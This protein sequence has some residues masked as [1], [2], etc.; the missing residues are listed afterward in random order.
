MINALIVDDEPLARE[1]LI[2]LLAPHGDVRIA[3]ECEDGESAIERLSGGGIDLLFLDVQMPGIDGLSVAELAPASPLPVI[4]FVTAHDVY[5]LRAF[6]AHA[7]DYLL[8]PVLTEQFERTLEKARTYLRGRGQEE[9][10]VSLRRELR[11]GPYRRRLAVR[12]RG[13]IQ[14]IR[15]EEVIW[16]ESQGNYVR[17][18]TETGAC[19]TREALYQFLSSVDPEQFLRVGRS[20]VV[21]VDHVRE[22]RVDR[23]GRLHVWLNESTRL[24]VGAAYRAAVEEVFGVAR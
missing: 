13:R 14:I 16:V 23:A 12:N 17:V 3:G 21:N 6:R 18:H 9:Q 1:R 15:V 20:S 22:L 19:L 7:L 4:I 11:G 24:P 8:K 10:L 5:A 2:M